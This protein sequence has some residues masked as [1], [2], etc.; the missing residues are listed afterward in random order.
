VVH[1]RPLRYRLDVA[2]TSYLTT[3]VEDYVRDRLSEEFGQTFRKQ[4][5]PLAPG[6]RHEFDAVS[7]DRRVVASI[8]AASG[9]TSGGRVPSGK[10]KDSL[11]ELYYL[12]L[13]DAPVRLLVLTTQAFFDIFT[14]KTV[15]AVAEGIRVSC[16]PLPTEIQRRVDDVVRIASQEV[17]P[18]T[19][20]AT[21]AG[22]IETTTESR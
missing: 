20:A 6:G 2:D 1:R 17:S 12:S 7:V 3:V 16:I 15:G 13:V 10:I 11:A 8:K 5:L 22:E 14:R 18:G 9:L 4:T 19:A 21:I